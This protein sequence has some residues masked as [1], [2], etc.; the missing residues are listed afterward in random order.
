MAIC[1]RVDGQ[2]G[3]ASILLVDYA[4]IAEQQGLAHPDALMDACHKRA[5]GDHDHTGD[6][7]GHDA[8]VKL[9]SLRSK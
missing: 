4:V 7:R 6:G 9:F 3:R 1:D 5:A 2:V 8:V